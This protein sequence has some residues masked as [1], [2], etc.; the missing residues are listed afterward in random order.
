VTETELI[1]GSLTT[2]ELVDAQRYV[3]MLGRAWRTQSKDESRRVGFNSD[4]PFHAIAAFAAAVLREM[5]GRNGA[6]PWFAGMTTEGHIARTELG[7]YAR[8][9]DLRV[10]DLEARMD[11]SGVLRR[12][13]AICGEAKPQ[14]ELS[15]DRPDGMW[16]DIC[17]PCRR[18]DAAR[19][20]EALAYSPPAAPVTPP[21]DDQLDLLRML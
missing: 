9:Y 1:L 21:V 2:E 15:F 17:R 5:T 19:L 10:R 11:P 13:C 4:G 12:V 3:E 20:E 18:I 7:V 14:D 8:R 16:S 6:E